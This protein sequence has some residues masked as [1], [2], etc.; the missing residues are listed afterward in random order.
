[1]VDDDFIARCKD[2][3]RI[4][5]VS[6]G[7]VV[8][9]SALMR[10]IDSGKVAGAAIDVYDQEPPA[11]DDPFRSHP[12]IICTPHLGASTVEAQH[13]V[14]IQSAHQMVAFLAEGK[15]ENAVNAP[16]L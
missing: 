2:G 5:N 1:M 15:I 12:G 16:R 9:A 8:D 4:V 10:G 14:G 6:R 11:E 3:V 13:N 7:P